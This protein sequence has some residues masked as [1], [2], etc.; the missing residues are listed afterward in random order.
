[1]DAAESQKCIAMTTLLYYIVIANLK[2]LKSSH[3][4][5][6]GDGGVF[7]YYKY[8]FNWEEDFITAN[9]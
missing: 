9:T 5:T 8:G 2:T 6:P 3:F 7:F 1:M 4:Q